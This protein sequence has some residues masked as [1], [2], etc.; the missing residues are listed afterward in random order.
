[1]TDTRNT[2]AEL[3]QQSSG[4]HVRYHPLME[5]KL[6]CCSKTERVGWQRISTVWEPSIAGVLQRY[7]EN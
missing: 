4:T 6:R 1:M 3:R 2:G 7:L 5:C